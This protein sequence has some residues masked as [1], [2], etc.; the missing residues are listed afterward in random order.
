[1]SAQKNKSY[2]SLSL[3]GF[4]IYLSQNKKNEKASKI[5]TVLRYQTAVPTP[6]IRSAFLFVR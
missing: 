4:K 5:F 3:A 1:M 6:I 2:A